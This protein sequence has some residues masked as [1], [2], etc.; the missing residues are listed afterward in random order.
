MSPFCVTLILKTRSKSIGRAIVPP[1]STTPQQGSDHYFDLQRRVSC[2]YECVPVY[3]RRGRLRNSLRENSRRSLRTLSHTYIH[4]Y[5]HTYTHT[6]GSHLTMPSPIS[7][8]GHRH[9]YAY[10]DD[11]GH[12]TP[13]DTNSGSEKLVMVESTS[14]YSGEYEY[15]AMLG[16][17]WIF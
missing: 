6:H 1:T 5:I 9:A 7:D 12:R 8:G 2:R 14:G 10:I 3:V 16:P 13:V 17:P 4:T 15:P 11:N